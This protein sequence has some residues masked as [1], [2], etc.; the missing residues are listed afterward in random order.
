MERTYRYIA[1]GDYEAAMDELARE[2][3]LAPPRTNVRSPIFSPAIGSP[4]M[5]KAEKSSLVAAFSAVSNAITRNPTVPIRANVLFER[6]DEGLMLTGTNM[7]KQIS[8][9]C[10][11][12]LSDDFTDFTAPCEEILK[13][14][15]AMADGPIRFEN[16]NTDG[17]FDFVDIKSGRAK[18]RIP[19]LPA[20]DYHKL[21][22]NGFT[23][24]IG[25]GIASLKKCL[26]GTKFAVSTDKGRPYLQGVLLD[27]L[28]DGLMFVG[29]DGYRLSQR[30]MTDIDE[31]VMGAPKVTIP[32]DAVS[33]LFQLLPDDGN[34]DIRLSS[35]KMMVRFGDVTLI[36]KLLDTDY[37]DYR[38][39]TP[40][41]TLITA[42]VSRKGMVDAITRVMSVNSD[43]GN[44]VRFSLAA[45]EMNLR[46]RPGEKGE[47]EDAIPAT[48]DGEIIIGWNGA[49]VASMLDAMDGDQIEIA[50]VDGQCPAIIRK[51]NDGQNHMIIMPMRV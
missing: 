49:Y 15:K 47:A 33:A 31:P 4:L 11:A 17:R 10:A 5:F 14:V 22:D 18:I 34:A 30:F 40:P 35:E 39:L 13:A 36:T 26:A 7:D 24:T 32:T 25:L 16:S 41:E 46:M 23:H 37:P 2:F 21:S 28:E 48:A 50:F 51:P 20:R 42:S 44:T 12:S 38:R 45:G 29:T 9:R 3:G 19:V 1:E 43:K 6:A 8:M 27:P